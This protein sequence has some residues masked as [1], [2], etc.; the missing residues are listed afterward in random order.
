MH[1]YAALFRIVNLFYIVN[2]QNNYV[3]LQ[4]MLQKCVLLFVGNRL[5]SDSKY[6]R[7]AW[8]ALH[9]IVEIRCE[10]FKPADILLQLLLRTE[11][12]V[13]NLRGFLDVA[14]TWHIHRRNSHPTF[15]DCGNQCQL[16]VLAA[17]VKSNQ[18]NGY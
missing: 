13:Y 16:T 3:R 2:M 10:I 1:V 7:H 4:E 12:K 14:G 8:G 6:V 5:T 15:H 17:N 18:T 9:I 11:A